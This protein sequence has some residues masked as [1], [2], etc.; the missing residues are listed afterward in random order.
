[1]LLQYILFYVTFFINISTR[2]SKKMSC[3]ILNRINSFKNING[4]HKILSDR[5]LFQENINKQD[6]DIILQNKIQNIKINEDSKK[7]KLCQYVINNK[8]NKIYLTQDKF[9]SDNYK[10]LDK[11]LINISPGGFKGFYMMGISAYI[12]ESFDIKNCIFSGAS[13]GAWNALLLSYKGEFT[14]L[15]LR[16]IDNAQKL[17]CPPTKKPIHELQLFLKKELL[18]L[19]DTN[20]YDLSKLFIGVT[21]FYNF[22]VKTNI[23]Y[24]FETLEDAID[25]C[26]ASSHIPFITGGFKNKYHNKLTFDGGF[27]SYPYLN[28]LKPC[29]YITPSMWEENKSNFINLDDYTTLF[30]RDKY[31]YIESFW[32]GYRD[33][34]DNY[35]ILKKCIY[36]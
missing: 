5:R 16:I 24:D 1:M 35:D 30:S 13:A 8:K 3:S 10:I 23:Y 31:D 32:K 18:E 21:C 33:A 2:I 12:K 22:D 7:R 9:L 20:D 17:K 34:K 6:D 36:E 4:I 14:H 28:I 15:L 25:C 27:S 19:T 11:K 29:I 26:I